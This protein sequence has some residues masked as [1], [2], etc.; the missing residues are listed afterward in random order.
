M[1]SK[2][3]SR[4]PANDG[5]SAAAPSAKAQKANSAAKK[6]TT[7]SVICM[8]LVM[9]LFIGVIV[10]NKVVEDGYYYRNTI[11]ASSE[12]YEIN[13]AMM[14]YYFNSSYQNMSSSM[15]QMGVDLQKNLKDQTYTSNKT[16]FDFI[17]ESYTVPQVKQILTLCEAAKAA[18]F[19]LDDHEREHIDEAIDTIK[20]NIETYSKQ[21]GGSE[22]FY[23]RNMY[24]HG[25]SMDDIRK[26]IELNQL[27]AAYSAHLQETYEFTEEEWEKHLNEH[28][29]DFQVIDYVTYS[30]TAKQPEASTTTTAAT[31]AP[32]TTPAT[33]TTE[34]VAGTSAPETDVA[35]S[36]SDE[37]SG[38]TAAT[39]EKK[40]EELSAEKKEALALANALADKMRAEPDKALEIFNTEVKKYLEDEVY[41]SETDEKKKAENVETSLK[42]TVAEG[43]SNDQTNDFLKFAFDT[44]RDQAK[45][46]FVSEDNST[47][48]YTVYLITKDPYIEEYL[49][50]DVLVIALSASEGDDINKERDNIIKEFEAGDKSEASFKALAEKYSD[51]SSAHETGGLYEN[52]T[53]TGLPVEELSDW[54]FSADRA[55]GDYNSASNGATGTSEVI[56]IVYYVG[57]GLIKW[58][59]DVDNT[60][61]AEAYEA[62]Y[63][64]L[65][66]A[67]KVNVSLEDA[68]KIP[69]QAGIS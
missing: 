36:A 66:E 54:L 9:A 45:D 40:E 56:Y 20:A 49:T 53:K 5:F 37:T 38:T 59:V 68:Y 16:W 17:M 42:A 10:Y 22:D 13:N 33:E 4:K 24:G 18:G 26:A 15:E 34:P 8:V 23:L 52:Q 11:S 47:G 50:K 21:Y 62:D 44:D 32:E 7:I 27:A 57:D 48:K 6:K 1:G 41:K 60:M 14:S 2:K 64:K 58:Q 43:A 29:A 67:H 63:K 51:D 30:F 46:I 12:N 19:E 65:E 55:A 61:T 25:V 39:T 28:K 69:G 35:A 31:S 3:N